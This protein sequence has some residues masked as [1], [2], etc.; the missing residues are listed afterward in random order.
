MELPIYFDD[1]RLSLAVLMACSMITPI[2][3]S[4]VGESYS[5]KSK[6]LMLSK[7]IVR[8]L[9]YSN[10]MVVENFETKGAEM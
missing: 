5:G 3:V 1:E 8:D 10:Y 2:S 9:I 7:L 4:L 6:L